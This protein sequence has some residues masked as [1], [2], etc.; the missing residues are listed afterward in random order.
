M[1]LVVRLRRWSCWLPVFL[2]T[3]LIAVGMARVSA[4]DAPKGPRTTIPE[5]KDRPRHDGFLTIAKAGGVD[6]LF[7]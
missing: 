7:M 4:A 6:L 1:N 5:E 3:C 2:V